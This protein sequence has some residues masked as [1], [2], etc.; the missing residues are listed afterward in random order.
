MER[1]VHANIVS[2]TNQ[3]LLAMIKEGSFR[4]DLYQRLARGLVIKSPPLR[5]APNEVGLLA[6]KLWQ[7][8]GGKMI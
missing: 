2:A 4:E 8:I 6:N 3:N 7:S 1:E 5:H